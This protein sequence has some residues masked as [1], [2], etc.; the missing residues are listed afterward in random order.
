MPG[1]YCSHCVPEDGE[2]QAVLQSVLGR[3][4][5]VLEAASKEGYA[6]VKHCVMGLMQRLLH[7]LYIMSLLQWSSNV[8]SL[9]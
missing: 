2:W 7:S 4:E 5:A 1:V 3:E 9:F 8:V 6:V